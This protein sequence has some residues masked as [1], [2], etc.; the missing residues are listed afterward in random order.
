MS[1]AEYVSRPFPIFTKIA[2][3][4]RNI[5]VLRSIFARFAKLLRGNKEGSE[6]VV[7]KFADEAPRVTESAGQP[8]AGLETSDESTVAIEPGPSERER[9]IRRRW[10]ETG[11]KMWNAGHAALNIQGRADLLPLK[12]GET[13]REYDRLEFKLIAGQIVC[14]G[15]IVD[16]PKPR[17]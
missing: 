15:V 14:E 8:S 10:A 16:P 5:P 4:L 11:I 9:L 17:K 7:S 12:P 13:R 6:P 1:L 2:V 3:M